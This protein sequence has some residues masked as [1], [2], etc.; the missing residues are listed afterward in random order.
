MAFHP[1]RLGWDGGLSFDVAQTTLA[2]PT[3]ATTKVEIAW[4][5]FSRTPSQMKKKRTLKDLATFFLDLT[6]L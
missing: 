3:K 2:A 6:S 1:R 5:R 4:S